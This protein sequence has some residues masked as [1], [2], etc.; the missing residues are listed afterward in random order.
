MEE[1]GCGG[2]GCVISCYQSTLETPLWFD[3]FEDWPGLPVR[4]HPNP[5]RGL[6]V[7]RAKTNKQKLTWHFY[8]SYSGMR[9]LVGYTFVTVSSHKR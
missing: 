9:L 2:I 7:L 8:L 6:F 3:I 5:R 1:G 4:N